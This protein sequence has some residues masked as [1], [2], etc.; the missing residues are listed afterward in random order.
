MNRTRGLSMAIGGSMLAFV[1]AIGA[2]TATLHTSACA[3]IS[4]NEIVASQLQV[5]DTFVQQYA[6]EHE[7]TPPSFKEVER[8]YLQKQ[9]AR[10]FFP[11]GR[12]RNDID[13]TNQNAKFTPR[14]GD[15]AT[16]LYAL[17]TDGRSYVLAGIGL[18]EIRRMV[19]GMPLWHVRNDFPILRLGD[20]MPKGPPGA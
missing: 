17:S 18:L 19:F 9:E 3:C 12:I 2:M 16:V 5:I 15:Q 13:P 20:P 10:R 6:K 7:G 8:M 11:G 14:E 1:A 4:T